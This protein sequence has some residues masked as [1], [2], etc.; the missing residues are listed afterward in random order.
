MEYAATSILFIEFLDLHFH[1][2]PVLDYVYIAGN[3]RFRFYFFFHR[4]FAVP[5]THPL[6]DSFA[7]Y[8][9]IPLYMARPFPPPAAAV[10]P[11]APPASPP[12]QV[13]SISLSDD[14]DPSEAMSSSFSSSAPGD[15][16]APTDASMANGFLSLESIYGSY[17]AQ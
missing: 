7:P 2:D 13:P 3:C 17:L 6:F 15:G 12:Q 10:A 11:V 16:Y 5:L 8:I 4:D 9:A 1:L 14:D